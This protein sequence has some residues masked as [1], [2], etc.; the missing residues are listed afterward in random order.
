MGASAVIESAHD[1][2]HPS[3]IYEAFEKYHKHCTKDEYGGEEL[4]GAMELGAN[5]KEP[6]L[7]AEG[8]AG[9][10][11][12]ENEPGSSNLTAMLC[13]S[14]RDIKVDDDHED[15]TLKRQRI[16]ETSEIFDMFKNLSNDM[17]NKNDELVEVKSA[18]KSMEEKVKKLTEELHEC[19]SDV[20]DIG[21]YTFEK[22][23]GYSP[24]CPLPP[25]RLFEYGHEKY[26]GHEKCYSPSYK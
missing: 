26:Y 16:M 23:S 5:T 9:V 7:E 25:D 4:E 18:L 24:G 17:K 15:R 20:R 3:K 12:Q 2:S 21:R 22:K 6:K 14:K 11:L 8:E 19:K 13:G 1:A 10:P